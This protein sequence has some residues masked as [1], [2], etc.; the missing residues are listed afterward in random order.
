MASIHRSVTPA[1]EQPQAARALFLVAIALVIGASWAWLAYQDW[2]MAHMDIVDM[3]M[4]SGGPWTRSDVALV[5]VMW[6]VMMVA[7]MLPSLLPALWRYRDAIGRAGDTRAGWLTA[8]AGAGYFVVWTGFG[9]VA[10]PLG[11]ALAAIEMQAPALA[12][13]VPIAVGVIVA[14]V[15]A[16]QFTAWKLHHLACCREGPR[17]GS[18]S[19]ADAHTAWRFGLRLGVQCS[20][21]CGSL[22]AMLLVVG[23]MDLVAMALVT[24]AITAERLA[25]AGERVA[26]VIGGI[27]VTAGLLMVAQALA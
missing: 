22:M 3:A 5:L 17:L 12:R 13:A 18:A 24:A 8:L 27:V 19:P 26:R 21:C 10:Y 14:I 11:V 7:M 20:Y 23:V 4:P 15:G 1:A 9:I 2:A 6:V 16:L 25:S